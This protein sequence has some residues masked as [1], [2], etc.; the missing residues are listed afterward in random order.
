M[1]CWKLAQLVERRAL[2]PKAAS[3]SLALPVCRAIP[4][5]SPGWP[6]SFLVG[7]V[8]TRYEMVVGL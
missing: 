6:D 2:D 5:V 8:E 1:S 4:L 7:D 3:S